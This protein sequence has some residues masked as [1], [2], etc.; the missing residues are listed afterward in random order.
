MELQTSFYTGFITHFQLRLNLF[1]LAEILV[2]ITSKQT[3]QKALDSLVAASALVKEQG[4]KEAYLL[5][6]CEEA[7]RRVHVS[8]VEGTDVQKRQAKDIIEEATAYLAKRD[9]SSVHADL[10]AQI[11]LAE[12]AVF[13]MEKK[14]GQFYER[15]LLYIAHTNTAKLP[16]SRQRELAFDLGVSAL[17][18]RNVHNFGELVHHPVLDTLKG[19]ENEWLADLLR[20]FNIGDIQEYDRVCQENE[21]RMKTC[22]CYP[23]HTHTPTHTYTHSSARVHRRKRSCVRSSA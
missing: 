22:V 19:S 15:C 2:T 3:D 16:E 6:R 18:A 17:L 23:M 12:A 5:L 13:K 21:A 9:A 14:H 4:N 8:V 1:S 10:R 20:T 7:I 11:Y